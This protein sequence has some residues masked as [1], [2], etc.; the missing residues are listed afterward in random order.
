MSRVEVNKEAIQLI[1]KTFM[2]SDRACPEDIGLKNG[3]KTCEGLNYDWESGYIK[4]QRC[5]LKALSEP[6]KKPR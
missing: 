2:L 5:F 6:P 4:C 3:Y 1:I